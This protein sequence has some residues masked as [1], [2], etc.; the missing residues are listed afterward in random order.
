MYKQYPVQSVSRK[1]LSFR[2]PPALLTLLLLCHLSGATASTIKWKV[3][4]EGEGLPNVV[5]TDG[6]HCV[7]TDHEGNFK[8]TPDLNARFIYISTPAGYLPAEENMVPRFFIPIEFTREEYDFSLRKNPLDD[9]KQLL[10]VSS[11]PQFHKE[12]NFVHY[13]KVVDDMIALKKSYN[14]WNVKWQEDGVDMGEMTRFEGHDPKVEKA[15]SN[16]ERL[17]F[18][19]IVP[20]L[21]DHLFRA[22]PLKSDS[23]LTIIAT[24]PFGN[25]YK[26]TI[27]R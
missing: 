21:T 4:S 24:D 3:T 6:Y 2:L 10:L 15:Y 13:A 5:V 20:E 25:I 23:K 7:I 19:W 16:K 14:N 22:T 27:E 26:E 1:N 12:E 17:E 8:L 11:D 9:T 18:S